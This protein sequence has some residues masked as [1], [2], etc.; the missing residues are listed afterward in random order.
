MR[1][2]AALRL[3][4]PEA[5]T[6]GHTQRKNGHPTQPGT[7]STASNARPRTK[8]RN[9]ILRRARRF[10]KSLN[11]KGRIFVAAL[12][13]GTVAALF[14][15]FQ[16]IAGMF[17]PEETETTGATGAEVPAITTPAEQL[18]E[19]IFRDGEGLPVDWQGLTAA[20]AAEAGFEK[21]YDLTDAER[22]E[23]ASVIT[24]EAEGEPFAGKVAVAQCILQACEDDGIGPFEALT[25]YKY[26]RYRPE[27]CEEALAAVQ[28]VFDFGHVASTEPI[29]Y[30]YA[31]ERVVS[32]WHES[33][34]YVMTIN[35]HRFFKEATE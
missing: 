28:A 23:I 20:W 33:Q 31:P 32:D 8:K 5:Y 29:K 25:K 21:R 2:T 14:F 7:R 4:S 3:Y 27:P 13:L 30:F 6:T 22:W 34:V 10:F 15:T 12:A 16:A 1:Q 26:S 9:T 17:A 18:P 24:A 11:W 35:G 19:Y